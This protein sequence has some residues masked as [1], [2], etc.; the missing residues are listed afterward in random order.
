MLRPADEPAPRPR[1]GRAG[2]GTAHTARRRGIA[3]Q[4]HDIPMRQ[5]VDYPTAESVE[6][7]PPAPPADEERK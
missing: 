2:R 7:I 3:L 5:S 4:R 6:L 1:A